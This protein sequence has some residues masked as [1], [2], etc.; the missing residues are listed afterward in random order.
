MESFVKMVH[1]INK[2]F[3]NIAGV[4]MILSVVLIITETIVRTVFNSTI[5]ITS[6]YTGYFLVAMTYLGLA[7]TLK[8]KGHIKMAFLYKVLKGE[9]S[10]ICLDLYTYIVGLVAFSIIL[11]ATF[12][13]FMDSV[14]SGTQSMQISKTYL[15]IPQSILPIGSLLMILQFLSEII[16]SLQKLKSGNIK[17]VEEAKSEFDEFEV[18]GR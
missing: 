9:K 1:Q 18:L 15:M 16:L 2:F 13:F 3:A 11:V 14:V 4:L 7:Y 6:E 10:R 5:Y 8:E 12:Q 17:Q